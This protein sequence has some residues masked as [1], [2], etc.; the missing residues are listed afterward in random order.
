MTFD[1]L[2]NFFKR[3]M[4]PIHN[5]IM[6]MIGRAVLS[7]VKDGEGIQQIQISLLAGESMD[8]VERFQNFGFTSHAPAGAEGIALSIGGNR[9]NLVVVALDHRTLRKKGLA[10]GESAMYDKDGN[11]IWLKATGVQDVKLKKLKIANDTDELITVLDDLIKAL[12]V[13][14]VQTAMGPQNFMPADIAKLVAIR[15][16]LETFKV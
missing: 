10:A 3:A 12:E 7:A 2:T 5:R 6:L 11:Y 13:A 15:T 16:R 4:Q 8:K 1:Q 14:Y 9:D